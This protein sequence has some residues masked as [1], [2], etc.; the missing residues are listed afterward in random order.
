MKEIFYIKKNF[1]CV[2]DIFI[3]NGSLLDLYI[4]LLLGICMVFI[5]FI[6]CMKVMRYLFIENVLYMFKIMFFEVKILDCFD[7]YGRVYVK[8]V[9]FFLY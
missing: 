4:R 5:F 7:F 6:N 2:Y 9:F 8:N 1:I 3:F